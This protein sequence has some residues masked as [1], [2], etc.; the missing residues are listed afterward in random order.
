VPFVTKGLMAVVRTK[1]GFAANEIN[2][3]GKCQADA[4][5]T[6]EQTISPDE[7]AHQHAVASKANPHKRR[8]EETA[9]ANVRTVFQ[10]VQRGT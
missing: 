3:P 7:C 6:C 4:K 9:H 8:A 5:R 1:C 2:Q 10:N